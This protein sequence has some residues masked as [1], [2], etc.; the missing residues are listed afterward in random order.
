MLAVHGCPDPPE[1]D[2]GIPLTKEIQEL[3]GQSK[4]QVMARRLFCDDPR[5][6]WDEAIRYANG[7]Y[8]CLKERF[9]SRRL[10]PKR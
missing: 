3:C 10:P 6:D 1:I 2:L 5:I 4:V 9:R 7:R 8:D